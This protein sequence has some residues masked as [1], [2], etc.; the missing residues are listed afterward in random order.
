[1]RNIIAIIFLIFLSNCGYSSVYKD[2]KSNDIFI[3]ITSIQGDKVMNNL[4][5]NQLE[6]Y[7]NK[8]SQN[9]YDIIISTNFQKITLAKNSSGAATNYQLTV[10]S[11]FEVKYKE[12]LFSFSF[13]ESL[14]IKN[15]SDTFEQNNYENTIKVN[16]ASSLREKLIIKLLEKQ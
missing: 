10:N 11:D 7:S 3:N 5:K 16:F 8:S 2:S 1:M 15:F 12:K 9:K 4:I 6:L 13:K 14:D